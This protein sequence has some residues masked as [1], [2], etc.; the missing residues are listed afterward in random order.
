MH[1]GRGLNQCFSGPLKQGLEKLKIPFADADWV[2]VLLAERENRR[3][4]ALFRLLVNKED[5]L[6]W[7]TLLTTREGIGDGLIDTVYSA[8][9]DARNTFAESLRTAIPNKGRSAKLAAALIAEVDAWLASNE[10]PEE[11]EDG[12]A[13]WILEQDLPDGFGFDNKCGQLLRD[14]DAL[15]DKDS[16]LDR[17]LGQIT[18]IG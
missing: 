11:P 18:P 2:K 9:K 8:A 4:L 6:A 12:W 14:V 13:E 3:A 10:L 5:S 17:F 7:A 16:S 15:M 1:L